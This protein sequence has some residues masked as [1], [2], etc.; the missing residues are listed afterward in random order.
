MSSTER[1]ECDRLAHYIDMLLPALEK[2]N[3]FDGPDS[4]GPESDK[5]RPLPGQPLPEN[6]QGIDAVLSDLNAIVIPNG[7]R[8]G[9]PGFAGWVATAPT[10]TGGIASLAA[11]V[12]GAHRYFVTS[13]NFLET[14]ALR[15]LCELLGLD[16]KFQDHLQAVDRS[17]I[18]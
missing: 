4:V 9:A 18:S 5:W 2:F 6:G 16:S 14:I 13:Y 8:F 15:W 17:Q 10:T 3:G 12:S 1:A 7:A 11:A